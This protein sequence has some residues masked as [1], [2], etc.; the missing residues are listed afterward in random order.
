MPIY[1]FQCNDCNTVFEVLVTSTAKTEEILCSRC[2]SK[3]VKKLLSSSGF[4]LASNVSSAI[5]GGHGCNPRG[6]F[7]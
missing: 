2:K 4:K 5:P 1:E 7:S 3:H 6:G